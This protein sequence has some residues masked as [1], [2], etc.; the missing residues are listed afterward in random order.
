MD[1]QA[2]YSRVKVHFLRQYHL[3]M[4][5]PDMLNAYRLRLFSSSTRMVRVRTARVD[6]PRLTFG[7]FVHI[8]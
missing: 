5:F 1:A 2:E 4:G 3:L 6:H 7:L 8:V